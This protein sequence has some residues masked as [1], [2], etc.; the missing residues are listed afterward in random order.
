MT[1]KQEGTSIVLSTQE[2]PINYR[3]IIIKYRGSQL[4]KLDYPHTNELQNL[5]NYTQISKN[6][7]EQLDCTKF[8]TFFLES[9]PG[10]NKTGEIIQTI[11][12]MYNRN[13][14]KIKNVQAITSNR[15]SCSSLYGRFNDPING[16]KNPAVYLRMLHHE[17]IIC[18]TLHMYPRL[19]QKL[20]SLIHMNNTGE[21][22]APD[23]LFVDDI[24]SIFEYIALSD[25]LKGRKKVFEILSW[26]IQHARYVFSADTNI[27][28]LNIE[29]LSNMR[30]QGKPDSS[31]QI[32]HNIEKTDKNSYYIFKKESELF[33]TIFDLLEQDKKLFI[34]TDDNDK[35]RELEIGI[36]SKYLHRPIMLYCSDTDD[37]DKFT[38]KD[39]NIIWQKYSIVIASKTVLHGVSFDIPYFHHVIGFY[40]N[41]IQPRSVYQQLN[42][43]RNI[44]DKTI[45]LHFKDLKSYTDEL[46]TNIED[47]EEDIRKSLSNLGLIVPEHNPDDLEKM[48]NRIYYNYKAD[49]HRS[50]NNYLDELVKYLTKYGSS[51]YFKV[52]TESIISLLKLINPKP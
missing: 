48:F 25:K 41:N 4:V 22:K 14:L 29:V 16:R 24:E 8:D 49:S 50:T 36:K 26:Y 5:P 39:C 28:R 18:E 43:V 7:V 46:S 10:T 38:I 21:F 13:D 52:G 23:I 27:S 3:S 44:I 17:D 47:I 51:V 30:Q 31:I 33:Y 35:S 15:V 2:K 11:A 32:I 9:G 1:N 37:I 42:R 40:Q 6:F 34:V 12:Q 45:F 19:V 20:D